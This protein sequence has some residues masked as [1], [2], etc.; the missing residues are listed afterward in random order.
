MTEFTIS[1]RSVLAGLGTIGIASAG[2]GL[3][4]TAFFSDEEAVSAS[5]QA[6][7]IDL[8]LDYRSTY[9]PWNRATAFENIGVIPDTDL[10][11]DGVDDRYVLDETPNV[12][13]TADEAAGRDDVDAGDLLTEDDWG[14]LTKA[15]G[16]GDDD[17]YDLVDGDKGVMFALDDVKPK[18]E[19]E[20]TLS[21]HSCDNP[22]YMW[23][24]AASTADDENQLYEPE[25]S[26]GDETPGMG[27]LDDF[28]YVEAWYDTNCNNLRDGARGAS[29]VFVADRSGSMG[30]DRQ[31]AQ[32]QGLRNFVDVFTMGATDDDLG[33]NELGLVSYGDR[34]LTAEVR[35]PLTSDVDDLEDAIDDLENATYTGGT[36]A[37]YGIDAA[38]QVLA[39]A[40]PDNDK[41]VVLFTDGRFNDEPGTQNVQNGSAL[42]PDEPAGGESPRS[43]TGATEDERA[44]NAVLDAIDDLRAAVGDVTLAT[45]GVGAAIEAPADQQF[46]VDIAD[47]DSEGNP[48]FFGDVED[49]EGI[50]T[51]VARVILPD[52]LLYRG[53]LAGFLDAA[54]E[55]IAL[56]PHQTENFQVDTAGDD[57]A[58]VEPGVTCV[59][60]NWYLPCYNEQ[61]PEAWEATG[62]GFSQ[63]PSSRPGLTDQD[64][65]GELT[66]ADELVQFAGFDVADLDDDGLINVTQ[67]D[68]AAFEVTAAAIQCRHNMTNANPFRQVASK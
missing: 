67:T 1:R 63:L 23:L 14:R 66:L 26:N 11:G 58:C 52:I 65:D 49:I 5:L 15:I 45:V 8:K 62:R 19:G 16:C 48:L 41:Y 30:P 61:A 47:E 24:R 57:A 42:G 29:A 39:D 50:I 37:Y 36:P 51:E 54:G 34:P 17:Q 64:G 59:A 68:G 43:A 21:L 40:D 31:A 7:K 38:R 2:A 60:V 28:V 56:N 4:T 33:N 44:R 3:G 46:L 6:G 18:D 27:E 20:F 35:S 25:D 32:A 10:D 12:R 9:L 13:Y 22:A 53:S 55:G